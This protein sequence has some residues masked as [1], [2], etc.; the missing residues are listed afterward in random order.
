LELNGRFLARRIDGAHMIRMAVQSNKGLQE[1]KD[2]HP[3]KGKKKKRINKSAI[4][5]H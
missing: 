4:I 5:I 2:K 1:F 3:Q